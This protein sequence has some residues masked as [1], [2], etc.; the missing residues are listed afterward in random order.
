M[1]RGLRT[2]VIGGIVFLVPVIFVLMIL[3]RAYELALKVATPISKIVPIESF[4]GLAIA[5]ILAAAVVVGV[6]YTAG[7]AARSSIISARVN[8]LDHFLNRAI[9]TYQPTKRGLIDSISDKALEDDWKVVL[10]G[11]ADDKRSLG[12]EVERL[13]NGDVAV[14]QPLSPNTKTGFV[15]TVPAANVEVLQMNPRELSARLKAYGIGI[16]DSI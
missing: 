3:R 16:S 10:V 6:C 14:F 13:E 7:V 12:F 5:N 4:G 1:G 2:T 8:K 15:W 9:P 11:K